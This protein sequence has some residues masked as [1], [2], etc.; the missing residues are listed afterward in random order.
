MSVSKCVAAT[1]IAAG[2]AGVSPALAAAPARV[3]AGLMTCD[4][5]AG[6]GLIIGSKRDVDCMFTP[7]AP[8]P[9]ERYAARSPSS[10]SI[11]ASSSLVR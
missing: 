1:L 6:I 3:Q 9:Q 8:G 4:I 2:L 7:S 5:S 11:S 10:A